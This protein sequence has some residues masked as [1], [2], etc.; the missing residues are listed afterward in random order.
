MLASNNSSTVTIPDLGT[1]FHALVADPR[2]TPGT[3]I[4]FGGLQYLPIP[5]ELSA[6]PAVVEIPTN[7][8]ADVADHL[9]E[10]A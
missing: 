8:K 3:P 4:K 1:T 9:P 6:H 2:G 10:K 5:I 7:D